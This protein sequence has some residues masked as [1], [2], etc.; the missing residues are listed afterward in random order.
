MFVFEDPETMRFFLLL[1]RLFAL[2]LAGWAAWQDWQS[3]ELPLSLTVPAAL[4]AIAGAGLFGDGWG[5]ALLGAA[6][7]FGALKTAQILA[8]LRHKKECLGSGDAILMLSL[9]ALTGL[10]GLP[11]A[12]GLALVSALIVAKACRRA[13]QARSEKIPFGPFLW[14]GSILAGLRG[15]L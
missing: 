10:P 9:G 11:W 5:S 6:A 13:G 3:L 15:W 2:G 14:A 12:L 8:R 4:I 1:S 7:G